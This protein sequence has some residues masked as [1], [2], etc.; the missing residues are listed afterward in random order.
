MKS[1]KKNW[2]SWS[3][4]P[5]MV[6]LCIGLAV[7]MVACGGCAYMN[8]RVGLPDDHA[9]EEAVESQIETHTGIEID[10][11]PESPENG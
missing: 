7:L 1:L 6:K 11:T 2:Q 5:I 4:L 3:E 8:Q 9:I 10:L